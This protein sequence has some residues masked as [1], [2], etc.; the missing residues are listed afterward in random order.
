MLTTYSLNARGAKDARSP[1]ELKANKT[2]RRPHSEA[3]RIQLSPRVRPQSTMLLGAIG[4]HSSR[5]GV[6]GSLDRMAVQHLMSA[7]ADSAMLPTSTTNS[8]E[9]HGTPALSSLPPS[10]FGRSGDHRDLLASGIQH[11]GGSSCPR[12]G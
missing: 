6:N 8:Q 5:I 4:I 2:M 12:G 7:S 3:L 11:L 9:M 10:S 1:R